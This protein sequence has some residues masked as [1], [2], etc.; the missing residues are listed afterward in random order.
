M[1]VVCTGSAGPSCA[2]NL[3]IIWDHG[4]PTEKGA[5]LSTVHVQS[6]MATEK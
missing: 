4:L 6:H 3:F 5:G 2:G 1:Y